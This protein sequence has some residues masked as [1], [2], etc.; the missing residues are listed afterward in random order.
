MTRR[1][2][3]MASEHPP[4]A[5]LLRAGG[6]PDRPDALVHEEISRRAYERYLARGRAAGAELDDWLEAEREVLERE[7]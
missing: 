7:Q 5:D 6:A 3:T 2:K 1:R 4:A